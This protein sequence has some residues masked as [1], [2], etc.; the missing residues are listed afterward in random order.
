MMMTE[1]TIMMIRIVGTRNELE[2]V[3]TRQNKDPKH[4]REKK[5]TL[6]NWIK[7]DKNKLVFF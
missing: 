2:N 5:R 1:T 6:F 3:K 4:T 7:Q